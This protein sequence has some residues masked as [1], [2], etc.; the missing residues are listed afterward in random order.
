[1]T[2]IQFSDI[3]IAEVN[4][5]GSFTTTIVGAESAI[6]RGNLTAMT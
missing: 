5:A 3:T 2:Y 1:M 6:L 4:I